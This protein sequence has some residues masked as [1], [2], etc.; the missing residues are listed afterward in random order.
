LASA[1]GVARVISTS[2]L[3]IT[4]DGSV[5]ALG[6]VNITRVL[7]NIGGASVAVIALAVVHA[8]RDRWA[9]VGEVDETSGR[10]TLVVGTLGVRRN[11]NSGEDASHNWV[12]RWS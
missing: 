1:C 5:G 3:V 10:N 4:S 7:A 8:S 12:A 11:R 9:Q 2:V 6:V